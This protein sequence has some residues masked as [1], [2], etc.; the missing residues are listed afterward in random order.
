MCRNQQR[1]ES[2][3]ISKKIRAC[4]RESN[5]DIDCSGSEDGLHLTTLYAYSVDISDVSLKTDLTHLSL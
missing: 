5:G 1:S 4:G 2:R 3:A